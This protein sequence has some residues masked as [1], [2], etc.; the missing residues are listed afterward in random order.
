M[1]L[2]SVGNLLFIRYYVTN[3]IHDTKWSHFL[4]ID[5]KRRSHPLEPEQSGQLE[6]GTAG[7]RIASYIP[8]CF[9]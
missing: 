5:D 3:K 8:E 2:K 7:L 9:E 1:V 4:Y 6:M